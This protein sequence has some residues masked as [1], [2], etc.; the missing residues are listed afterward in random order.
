M[1]GLPQ[2]I[3]DLFGRGDPHKHK[4]TCQVVEGQ[5]VFPEL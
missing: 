5:E 3:L 4:P 2:L 1:T